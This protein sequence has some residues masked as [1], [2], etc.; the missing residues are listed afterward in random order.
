VAV[1]DAPDGGIVD[2]VVSVNDAVA[3]SNDPGQ[4]ADLSGRRGVL[5]RELAEC[6]AD[7]LELSLNSTTELAINL[8]FGER[9]IPTPVA[10]AAC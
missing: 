1:D 4:L 5:S 7:D 2:G 3:E 9:A 6:L 8:V 10:N